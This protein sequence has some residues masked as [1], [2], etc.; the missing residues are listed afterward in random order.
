[1]QEASQTLTPTSVTPNIIRSGR[2]QKHNSDVDNTLSS[3][4]SSLSK[5]V[6]SHTAGTVK[7]TEPG[8]KFK[9]LHSELDK[10]LC[11]LPFMD[12]MKLSMEI[13]Q[14]ANEFLQTFKNQEALDNMGIQ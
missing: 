7:S 4:A 5:L 12:A 6:E 13:M 11:Q 3:V 8:L 10:V 1:M 9:E 2:S 14:R